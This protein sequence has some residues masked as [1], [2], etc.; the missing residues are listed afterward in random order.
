MM[1]TR[2]ARAATGLACLIVAVFSIPL[3][4]ADVG[5][6]ING[7]GLCDYPF[8]GVSFFFNP[9]IGHGD[10][11][12]C[13]GP[14]E[15]NGSYYVQAFGSYLIGGG[16]QGGTNL[17]TSAVLGAGGGGG[18]VGFFCMENPDDIMAFA[19][20]AKIKRAAVPNPPGAWKN[21]IKPEPCKPLAEEPVDEPNPD[22][23]EGLPSKDDKRDKP[24]A[25]DPNPA[26]GPAITNPGD[27]NPIGTNKENGK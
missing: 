24:V 14:Q 27:G 25:D 18:Q 5:G 13:R 22:V 19:D 7:P 16:I 26:Q 8:T 20:P 10:G 11:Y 23:T 15:I 3:A 6:N 4:Y 21:A 1:V 12:Y 2:I 17:I 9:L